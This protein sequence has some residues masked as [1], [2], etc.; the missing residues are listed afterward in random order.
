LRLAVALAL[1]ALAVPPGVRAE[2]AA[3]TDAPR[4]VTIAVF[5]DS[6]A[7]GLWASLYR[8][9]ARDRSVRIVNATRASTGFNADFHDEQLDRLL[10]RPHIDLLI[11]QTGAN[12]RQRAV[13]LDGR[14]KAAFGSPLWHTFY[15][16]RLTHFL[17]RVQQR[18][19]PVVWV[20]LP[21]MRNAPYD[22]GMRLL[23]RLHQ[24]HAERH[25]ALFL[26]IA[27]FTADAD[28]AF[29]EKLAAGAGRVR[30]FR[31]VD[32]VHFWEFGYDRVA[33][34]VLATIRARFPRLLPEGRARAEAPS[35]KP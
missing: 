11:V 5:G 28:G 23:S 17:A 7:E 8:L 18:G 20:G 31:H 32:G 9:F 30:R 14:G 15:S 25:G 27:G 4:P 12:D 35:H 19:I 26:D 6:L 2:L 21:V 29:V 34:H 10:R 16:Q 1:I 3:R 24:E 22:S 13:A 33:A